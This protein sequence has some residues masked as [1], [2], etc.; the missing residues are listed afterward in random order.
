[1]VSSGSP[2]VPGW[3][4]GV[5]GPAGSG[6][7]S[8]GRPVRGSAT[9]D[10]PLRPACQV[11]PPPGRRRRA[12]ARGCRDWDQGKEVRPRGRTRRRGEGWRAA[13]P[14][15]RGRPAGPGA[16][17]SRA[18][19][20]CAPSPL[21]GAVAAG[22]AAGRRGGLACRPGPQ[23]STLDSARPVKSPSA[24]AGLT[25]GPEPRA[26][27]AGARP[28]GRGRPGT[29]AGRRAGTA[30]GARWRAPRRCAPPSSTPPAPG[31][32]PG[33]GTPGPA[34]RVMVFRPLQKSGFRGLF[35]RRT[36]KK[37]LVRQKN[38]VVAGSHVHLRWPFVYLAWTG[39]VPGGERR[40]S[41]P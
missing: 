27:R 7:G 13:R 14:C 1:M 29:R 28:A 35:S 38:T 40:R 9:T 37:V 11:R 19:T 20:S 3:S 33:T 24:G 18:V 2:G 16:G 26:D 39:R 36:A 32:Q 22:P 30:K 6:L 4:A 21:P 31:R 8:R 17:W 23:A 15:R 12:A 25:P 10:A 41:A 5:A 34:R